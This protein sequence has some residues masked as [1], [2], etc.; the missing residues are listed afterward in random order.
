MCIHKM[1]QYRK[2]QAQGIYLQVQNY[3]FKIFPK[4]SNLISKFFF[5]FGSMED[6]K[7]IKKKNHY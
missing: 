4:N 2:Q 7:E 6:K 5:L 1:N 3:K